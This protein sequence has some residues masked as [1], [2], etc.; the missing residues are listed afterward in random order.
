MIGIG[1]DFAATGVGNRSHGKGEPQ[2]DTDL[3][4]LIRRMSM[5]NPL[6]QRCNL[7]KPH[8]PVVD[9]EKWPNFCR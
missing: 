7:Q 9:F 2:I 5:E 6:C 4:A 8:F 3:R 1:P